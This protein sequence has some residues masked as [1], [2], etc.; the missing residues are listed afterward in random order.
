MGKPRT[1]DLYYNLTNPGLLMRE[2]LLGMGIEYMDFRKIHEL[3]SLPM[4]MFRYKNL[5]KVVKGL[6]SKTLETA[7][8]F[9]SKLC[10]Y[11][12]KMYGWVLATYSTQGEN[13]IYERETKGLKEEK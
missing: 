11:E 6:D 8:M 2:T 12:S 4:S 5:D 9:R 7:L 13:D 10:F 3:V 1:A